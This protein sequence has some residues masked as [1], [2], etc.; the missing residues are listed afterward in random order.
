MKDA[1]IN[2]ATKLIAQIQAPPQAHSVWVRTSVNEDKQFEYTLMASRNPKYTGPWNIP[3]T[4]DGFKVEEQA[5][6][7]GMG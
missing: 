1:A 7:E 5:W 3:K 6:P 4:I 2:A